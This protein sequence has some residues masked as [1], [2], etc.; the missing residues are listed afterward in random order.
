MQVLEG[1]KEALEDQDIRFVFLPVPNKENIYHG[2]FPN[3]KK[4]QYLSRLIAA[5]QEKGVEV[6]DTQTAFDKA[7]QEGAQLYPCD[8]AHW[9]PEGVRITAELIAEALGNNPTEPEPPSESIK[10]MP[11]FVWKQEEQAD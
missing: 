5:L 9:N 2:L 11:G 7:F 6:I 10:G 4:P 1:Y 8:D 3:Q